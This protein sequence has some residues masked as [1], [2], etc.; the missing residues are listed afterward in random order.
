MF[1]RRSPQYDLFKTGHSYLGFVGAD[2][3]CDFLA[4]QRGG[5]FG[6]E[7]FTELYS[8]DQ[9]R[10]SMLAA[11]L[12]LPAHDAVSDEEAKALA[13]YDLLSRRT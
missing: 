1:G 12:L 10:A 13:R 2:T 11:I 3:F 7:E 9:G 8:P 6:D 5:L 4:R